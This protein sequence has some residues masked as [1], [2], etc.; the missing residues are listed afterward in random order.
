MKNIIYLLT[1]FCITISS[2]QCD[3]KIDLENDLYSSNELIAYLETDAGIT[4]GVEAYKLFHSVG[5]EKTLRQDVNLLKSLASDLS[6]TQYNLKLQF[7]EFPEDVYAWKEI[8]D[9]PERAFEFIKETD[10]ASWLRFKKSEFFKAITKKGDDFEIAMLNK[11]KTRTGPE[12]EKLKELIPDIDQRKLVS[13]MQ[14]CLPGFSPPCNAKGEFFIADQVWIKYDNRGRI[15]DMV[16]VDAK[17]SEG[18]ALTSGQTAAK[19]QAGKGSLAYKPLDS[20]I[21]DESFQDLPTRINQGDEIKIVGFYKLYGDGN[22]N[23][24]SIKKL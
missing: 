20:K 21:K 13:Q 10:N 12:Y 5:F 14:F 8:K 15:Q 23:F 11:V 7:D 19:N 9:N 18:T 22:S 24:I 1:L 3:F 2:G 17:L 4:E 16:V 6:K